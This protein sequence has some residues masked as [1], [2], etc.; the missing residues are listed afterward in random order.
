MIEDLRKSFNENFS[1]ENFDKLLKDLWQPTNNVV[2]F[3]V[4]ETPIFIPNNLNEKLIDTSNELLNQISSEEFKEKSVNAIPDNLVVP[5]EDEHPIF[6]QIDFGITKD[7]EGVYHPK[8]IELQGFPSL[9]AYQA[10][11]GEKVK[12]YFNLDENLT[13][14]YSDYDYKSYID[15]FKKAVLGDHNP[16]NVV[17]LEVEPN[18]QKTRIDFIYT[19]NQLGIE[20]ICLSDIIKKGSKLFYKKKNVD[21]PIHRIYNR[22]IFDELFNKKISYN[23][24]FR[25]DLD[26]EWAGHPNWFYKVSKYSLPLLK[27]ASVPKSYYLDSI[28]NLPE[29][30]SQ[31][32]LKPLFSF[33]GSGVKVN[34]TKEDIENIKDPQNYILQEKVNYTPIIETLDEPAKVEIRLMFIWLD[35]PILVNNLVRYS[36]GAMMGVDFNKNK[37]WIGASIGYHK[38]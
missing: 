25:D 9:Y 38:N 2:D 4:C 12:K 1:N 11:L 21:I 34:I 26:V 28:I 33:A 17:L 6:L 13:N 15:L 37:T 30:L 5:N 31:Y 14:F 18:N 32:V 3:R 29:N 35:K 20:Y 7:D 22:V 8:L 16:E 36:K 10:E 27:H 23:F 24:D 19:K